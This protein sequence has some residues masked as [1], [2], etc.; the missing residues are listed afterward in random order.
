MKDIS[1]SMIG[2][3]AAN[4]TIAK[5]IIKAG[6][7]QDNIIMVDSKGTLHAERI[8]L[9]NQTEKWKICKKTNVEERIGGIAE[10]IKETDV[11]I[12]FSKSGPGIITEEMVKSLL[13]FHG[14]S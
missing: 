2:S 11:R 14:I 6:V 1:V 7:K 13:R 3:G 8:D 9:K 12:A 4:I 10:A 5:L